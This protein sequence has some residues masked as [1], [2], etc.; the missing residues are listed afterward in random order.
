[1]PSYKRYVVVVDDVLVARKKGSSVSVGNGCFLTRNEN[2]ELH[3]AI[4]FDCNSTAFDW[5][6]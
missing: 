2:Y 3:G 4:D 5:I 6:Q 1:M